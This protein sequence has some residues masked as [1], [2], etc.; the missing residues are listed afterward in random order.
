MARRYGVRAPILRLGT[1]TLSVGLIGGG[2][3]V[4]TVP[5]RCTV[6]IDRRLLPG[7]DAVAAYQ[8]FIAALRAKLDPSINLDCP[9][10][11]LA[12]PALSSAG[13]E[14]LVARL[15]AAIDAVIGA[16]EVVAV[17]YGTDAVPWQRPVCPASSSDR[18]TSPRRTP[19]TNGCRWT[20]WSRPARS[21]TGRSA[22]TRST[23]RGTAPGF[24]IRLIPSQVLTWRKCREHRSCRPG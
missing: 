14:P 6:E 3:S 4:N 16:H 5:D 18:E 12:A 24:R 10:P 23:S 21:C 8:H 11:Y 15:G 13:S 2:T 22:K 7:E 17:P 20:R 19:A 9:Q 1:P